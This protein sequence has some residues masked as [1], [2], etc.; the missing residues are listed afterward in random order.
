VGVLLTAYSLIIMA[1]ASMD[2]MGGDGGGGGG[3]GLLVVVAVFVVGFVGTGVQGIRLWRRL[4]HGT[5]FANVSVTAGA[6]GLVS[7]RMMFLTRPALVLATVAIATGLAAIIGTRRGREGGSGRAVTGVGLG[8]FTY[9][10]VT[11]RFAVET[12]LFAGE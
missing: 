1:L 12:I 11:I 2:D 7:T 3:R 8:L 10:F 6:L 9:V 5:G 4:G